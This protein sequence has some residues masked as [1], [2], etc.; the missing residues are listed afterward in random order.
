MMYVQMFQTRAS[1]GHTDVAWPVVTH[2]KEVLV[3]VHRE[4]LNKHASPAQ[5]VQYLHRHSGL[6]ISLGHPRPPQRRQP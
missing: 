6:D 4:E 1:L 5:Q 2:Q 3:E